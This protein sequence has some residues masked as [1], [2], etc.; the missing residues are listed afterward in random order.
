M[1]A[2]RSLLSCVV[3]VTR[4]SCASE[5]ADLALPHVYNNEN[6]EMVS[7]TLPRARA[8][9][10][11]LIVTGVVLSALLGPRLAHAQ[12]AELPASDALPGIIAWALPARHRRLSQA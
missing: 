1:C 4:T 2:R 10:S 5:A 12:E 7:V 3:R 8:A 11:C 9:C 6:C